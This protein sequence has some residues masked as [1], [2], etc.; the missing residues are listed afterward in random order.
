[1]TSLARFRCVAGCVLTLSV[2]ALPPL[3]AQVSS[4]T[5]SQ[6]PTGGR[7]SLLSFGAAPFLSIPLGADA[8]VFS[9]GG[10]SDLLVTYR[11]PAIPLL[12][13][14]GQLGYGF[15][16]SLA[17]G[18]SLSTV[19]L[20]AAAG[21]RLG[22][23][24]FL[25][26][27][28]SAGG[29][30]FL[31]LL[32]GTGAAPGGNPYAT[33]GIRFDFDVADSWSI[34]VGGAYRYFGGLFG[35]TAMGISGTYH[36][37]AMPVGRAVP[38]PEGFTPL[39][40][41]GR[42]LRITGLKADPVFP[43]FSKYYD[44]H[45]LAEVSLR[46]F[47][48]VPAEKVKLTAVVKGYMDGA[49]ESEVPV[50]IEPGK[51]STAQVFGLFNDRLLEV[52]EQTKLTLSLVLEYSQYGK[53]Y[54]DE[55]T[56]SID[57]LYRNAMIWE[58][59]RRMAAFISARDPAASGF[60]RGVLA[61]ARD[62][63]NPALNQDLQSAM[64][65]YEAL[66]SYGL[67]Y[68]KDP[69]SALASGDRRAVDSLQFPQETLA[70]RNGDCDDLSILYCSM[71]ES[72]GV[73]T[74]FIT[75]PGHVFAA[76]QLGMRPE[77]AAKAYGKSDDFIARDGKTWVP[78]EVTAL[79]SDFLGAWKVGARQ[80]SA[81][82][83]GA[84][85][86]PVHEA[87]KTFAP[88]VVSGAARAPVA[89]AGGRLSTALKAGIQGLVNRELSPRAEALLA[90]A[91]KSGASART[92]NSLGVLYAR[93]GQYDKAME[94]FTKASAKGDYRPALINIGNIYLTQKQYKQA[95]EQ[96]RRVLKLAPADPYG[97]AGAAMAFDG[98][99][100]RAEAGSAYERLKAT[101]PALAEQL[102]YLDTTKSEG[103]SRAA[104]ADSTEAKIAWND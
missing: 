77:D 8:A 16:P 11:L 93:Y 1:M 79:S 85:F 76:F 26:L 42:G 99:G 84:G 43:V 73:E 74:A 28:L 91:K 66:R 46:N 69:A 75:T 64:V 13:V 45:P 12:F 37:P 63:R 103:I 14:S 30:Y 104:E 70:S 38:L 7:Y 44:Q 31:G 27:S 20:G 40:N 32:N 51:G 17:P 10:G 52:A 90:D 80:W 53:T 29:G 81:E 95:S 94:Q 5:V 36:L 15:V 97:L 100:N 39:S 55:Y 25:S 92:L 86:Y 21:V 19:S 24:P 68:T 33:A 50:R 83:G 22:L 54:R 9:V 47:E 58:D 60:A 96:F 98:L 62:A 87:W 88:V 82:Q 2:A 65:I 57:V 49:R 67:I 6:R 34:G 102:A 101:D 41:D 78:V 48:G 72:I 18:T 3:G 89:P 56:P 71:L 4:S 35:D 61:A 59:D 23:L